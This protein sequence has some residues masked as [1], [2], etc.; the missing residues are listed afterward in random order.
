MHTLEAPRLLYHYTTIN[1]L[2]LILQ[3]QSILFSR[4]DKVNDSKEGLTA[5][6]VA[7]AP[8]IFVS[9]WTENLHENL[10]LWNMYT[11]QMRGIRIELPNPIFPMYEIGKNKNCLISEDK[12]VNEDKNI[13]I[14]PHQNPIYKI[15]Y[16]NDSIK[17]N[18]SII[19]EIG[20]HI[21]EVGMYKKTIWEIETEWR[22]RLNIIPIDPNI[23]SNNFP[24][25]YNHLL[26][27]REPPSISNYILPILKSSFNQMKIL[28]GPKMQA[29]DIEIIEALVKTYN[30]LAKFETS[31]LSNEIR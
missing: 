21:G 15:Q 5:D 9:C 2:A 1:N 12:V 18:P 25:R 23:K 29:G 7:W 19:K 13:F 8:Y 10:A 6:L 16:T 30:P 17:L 3:S 14:L 31:I 24:D 26:K 27:R 20:F 11:P 22:F 28:I 4:L